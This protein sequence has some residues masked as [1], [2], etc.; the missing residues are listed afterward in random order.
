MKKQPVLSVQPE[1]LGTN[2]SDNPS[3]QTVLE[4][5]LSRRNALF[6]GLA[7]T[8][9]AV[10]ASQGLTGCDDDDDSSSGND[11]TTTATDVTTPNDTAAVTL[12]ALGFAAVA[13]NLD[14]HV[15]VPEG[16][17]ASVLYALGD[18]LVD[19]V[20][21]YTNDGSQADFDKRAGDHHDGIAYFSFPRGSN[22]SSE[23]LLTL[24]HENL[25]EVYLH[26]DGPTN[27][28][29]GARPLEEALKEQY[30][31]GVSVIRIKQ[32]DGKWSVDRSAA[33]NRRYHVNSEAE[34]TGPAA[35]HA[36]L[37]TKL[38]P[39]GTT[40]YGTINNCANGVTPWGTYLTCEENWNGYFK[41]SEAD[42]AASDELRNTSFARYGIAPGASGSSSRG[43]STAEDATDLQK[44]FDASI[45]G[46]DAT[47]DFR[48]EPHTFGYVVEIDPFNPA[49]RLKKRTALGRFGH[50]GA[51]SSNPTAGQPLAFYLGD[52]ARG[53]YVYKFVTA[54]AWDAADAADA[55]AGD[56]YLNEGTLYV[57]KFNADGSGEWLPLTTDNPAL[58]SFESDADIAINTRLAADAAGATKLDRPEWGAVNPA[59]GEFYLTLTNNSQRGVGEGFRVA[60]DAANPRSYE[61]T[62]GEST[63]SGNVNGHILRLR[64][65][66]NAAAA[67]D[68]TWDVYL[69]G[70]QADADAATVNLSGLTDDNDFSS[71]DGLWFDPRGVLWIETDD[72]AYTDVTNNQ[73]LAALPGSV[74]DGGEQTV[75]GVT[76]F[77]GKA[78]TADLVR[79]FLTGPKDS[80]ITGI[81]IT[82]DRK[83]LFVNIQHPGEDGDLEEL[84]S[85]WPATASDDA[86]AAGEAGARP[87]SATVAIVKND[88]GEIGA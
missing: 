35:G 27:L 69:F 5:R 65:A 78:A 20:D 24:N 2:T 38:S 47:Q 48:N 60:P 14:D 22:S 30:A 31:H 1:D 73:L 18:P 58:S 9:T 3:L 66:E 87:R 85:N 86:T 12:E 56:K 37:K 26:P 41:R 64:E 63:Q 19:D 39:D 46:T 43:W 40:S 54:A 25:T 55:D 34:F 16:Y 57:A 50:E 62:K 76:T 13:K 52:D 53:E 70:A 45:T 6:A 51:W 49:W 59:N 32:Q 15:T 74:G 72:G 17:S 21:D 67:T 7:V 82:P 84:T 28:E 11:D 44:R 33:E 77:V 88:G 68:F 71:P 8:T 42:E 83:T 10:L 36:L 75:N 4:S 61:D 29:E 79:R 81:T 23:G 80:E